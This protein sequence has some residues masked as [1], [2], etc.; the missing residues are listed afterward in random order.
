MFHS[1][2]HVLL[3]KTELLFPP[4]S[5]YGSIFCLL[6]LCTW[7]HNIAVSQ[8]RK[9]QVT[10]YTSLFFPSTFNQSLVLLVLPSKEFMNWSIYFLSINSHLI[11]CNHHFS[12]D[13][14]F[15]CSW[16]PANLSSL[17]SH[18]YFK[19]KQKGEEIWSLSSSD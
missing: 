4:Y 3:S 1:H 13:W 5:W 6:F 9:L 12:A 16:P 8:T 2:F 14:F 19:Q 11:S 10:P 7:H 18:G 17:N 15:F